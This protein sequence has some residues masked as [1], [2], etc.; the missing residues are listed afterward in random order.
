M[1]ENYSSNLQQAGLLSV[2]GWKS[3]ED[4]FGLVLYSLIYY[5]GPGHSKNGDWYQYGMV[6]DCAVSFNGVLYGVI[7]Y[8]IGMRCKKAFNEWLVCEHEQ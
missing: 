1:N 4:P 5:I 6:T 8:C 2:N 7:W 3:Q